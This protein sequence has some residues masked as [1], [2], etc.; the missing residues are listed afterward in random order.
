MSCKRNKRIIFILIA[1][2]SFPVFSNEF[3]NSLVDD[4]MN[5]C[6][7]GYKG[8]NLETGE[9]NFSNYIGDAGYI[10]SHSET[11]FYIQSYKGFFKVQNDKNEVYYTRNGEFV[12]RGEDYYL[13]YANYKLSTTIEDCD[14]DS[15]N[16]K[17]LIYHPTNNCKIIRNGYLFIFS[18]VECFE[19]EI[20]PNRLELPNI[21]SI[22]I[23][24][25]MKSILSENS[26]QYQ[27]QLD[28]INYM[29]TVLISDKMHEY[30]IARSYMQFDV[31][32]YKLETNQIS[33]DELRFIYSTNW[34]RTFREYIKLL[35]V[36]VN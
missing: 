34:G 31:E 10:I 22:K 19:E 8:T 2:L 5:A 11:S 14:D 13:A 32:K 7:Y 3:Y 30:H 17:T 27:I 20:I 24:L 6:Q 29:L 35:Y 4:L 9:I 33:L 36:D 25:K 28:I 1:F 18:E 16:K 26:E 21:D 12:K 23:L 15:G